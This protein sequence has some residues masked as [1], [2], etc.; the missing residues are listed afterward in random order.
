MHIAAKVLG[1][2]NFNRH[3]LYK[4]SMNSKKSFY[5]L[6]NACFSKYCVVYFFRSVTHRSKH[7]NKDLIDILKEIL[8]DDVDNFQRRKGNRVSANPSI[9]KEDFVLDHK[10]QS[11]KINDA[12]LQDT[13]SS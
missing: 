8:D 1:L 13:D 6:P 11:E 9:K 10:L 5:Y 2:V 12:I 3:T 7:V 4:E